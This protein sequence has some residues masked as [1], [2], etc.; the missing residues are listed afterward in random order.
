MELDAIVPAVEDNVELFRIYWPPDPVQGRAG[1][2]G[3]GGGTAGCRT[4]SVG[5]NA[6]RPGFCR[7][8][9]LGS[10]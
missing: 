4:R 10:L 8:P 3:G 7:K 1:M 9:S 6:C 2:F 5:S